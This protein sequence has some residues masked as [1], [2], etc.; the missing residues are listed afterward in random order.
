MRAFVL[1]GGAAL[2][3]IAAPA[4]GQAD[5][6]AVQPVAVQSQ[7]AP[8]TA[9]TIDPDAVAALKRMSDYLGTLKSFELTSN[10]TIDVVTL[11]GQRVQ[12]GALIRYKV[13]RPGIRIDFDGDLRDRQFFYDGKTFT[14]NAPKLNFYATAPAPPTNQ[15]F[16]KA[17]YQKFGIS[18]PL[19]DLFR[20]NDGDHSDIDALTSAFSLGTANIDGVATDHWA[21]RQGVFDWEVWIEQGDRPIPRKLVIVDRTDPALPAY[22]ARLN[23]TLN[24][25]LSASDFTFVPDKSA[26]RIPLATL[27]EEAK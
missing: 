27:T 3:L 14:I 10:S 20:W 24:P 15:E 19:D 21:F 26:M 23:W 7:A 25:A 6:S 18:L 1:S 22:T 4:S 11:S 5:S 17:I 12:L 13:M 8:T 16:L 9:T 2:V